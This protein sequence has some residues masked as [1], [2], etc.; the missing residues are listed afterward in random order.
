M[1]TMRSAG[2][3]AAGMAVMVAANQGLA[4]VC[5]MSGNAAAPSVSVESVS[6]LQQPSMA[7]CGAAPAAVG[8]AAA[9]CLAAAAVSRGSRKSM[10]PVGSVNRVVAMEAGGAAKRC[11]KTGNNICFCGSQKSDAKIGSS[12]AAIQHAGSKSSAV[13]RHATFPGTDVEID[14]SGVT[15][16]LKATV[17]V[18][19]AGKA[20]DGSEAKTGVTGTITFTQTDA[21]NIT[22][23]YEVRGL[24]PGQHGFHVHEKADFSNGCASAGPHYNP[25]KKWHGGPDD[26]E[27]HVGDL[28]N[29]VAGE[30]GVAKG[31]VTDKLI[32]IFGEYTVVGRSIMIHADP[33]DL[34]RGDPQGWPETA[35]PA[36]PAQHTK[37]T[38]NAGA[39]IACG[40][41]VAA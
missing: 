31:S 14:A 7:S 41:I 35:P 19:E 21:E 3:V 27:R 9:V 10:Q 8:A 1:S 17:E 5:G 12:A 33:D 29:I 6:Q 24:A 39:R 15:F 25:F 36:A 32:K 37:T 16:P 30:D 34:G 18:G 26:L 38:G 13:T 11:P 22:V 40:V 23:D 2:T 4:W 20:C 28:G